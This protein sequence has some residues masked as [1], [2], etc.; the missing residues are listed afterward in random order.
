VKIVEINVLNRSWYILFILSLGYTI[1][2]CSSS[3]SSNYR[4]EIISCDYQNNIGTFIFTNLQGKDI[5]FRVYS[6]NKIYILDVGM[7]VMK[8]GDNNQWEITAPT[9]MGTYDKNY[10]K[11]TIIDKES[12][13]IEIPVYGTII[14]TNEMA[15]Y[16]YRIKLKS[17]DGNH[18]YYSKPY[19]L[20]VVC[21]NR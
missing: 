17:L 21:K 7:E 14:P 18:V 3:N 15:D 16:L 11:I 4:F 10:Q 13:E 19:D 12:Q 20:D 2:G 5:S 9:H 8:K 1:Y 6:G